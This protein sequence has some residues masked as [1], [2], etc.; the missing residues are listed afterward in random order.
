[1]RHDFAGPRGERLFLTA[2][3]FALA[4]GL[5]EAVYL[6]GVEKVLLGKRISSSLHAAWMIPVADL[7]FFLAPAAV[8]AVLGRFQPRLAA[9]GLVFGLFSALTAAS[10]LLATE[11]LH[12]AAVVLLAAGVGVEAARRLAP[13]A[14]RVQAFMRRTAPWLA[15]MVVLAA[16]TVTGWQTLRELRALAALPPARPGSPNVLLLVMDTVRA[17]SVSAHGYG[18]PTTPNLERLARQGIRFRWAMA[19]APWTLPTHASIFTGRLPH[20]LSGDWE[21]PLDGAHPTLAEALAALGYRTAGFS[22]NLTFVTWEWGLARGFSRF[23]DYDVSLAQAL[24]SPALGRSLT[25]NR[26]VRHVLGIRDR[27]NRRRAHAMNQSLLRWVDRDRSR[28]FF[29]FVNYFDAHEPYLPPGPF[30][31]RFGPLPARPWILQDDDVTMPPA[32]K[33]RMRNAYEA[34]IASLDHE[35]GNLMDALRRRGLLDNTVTVVTADHGEQFGEHGLLD[36]GNSLYLPLLHVP[37]IVTLPGG[38]AAGRV[39]EAT[40]SLR[41]LPATVMDLVGTGAGHPLPG[42]SLAS[43]WRGATDGPGAP[44]LASLTRGFERRPWIPLS[45][46]DMLSVVDDRYHYIRNGDGR[47]ELY[48]YRTDPAEERDLAGAPGHAEALARFRS[49]LGALLG[50]G[51]AAGR[52]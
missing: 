33:R 44:V 21:V 11:R 34:A 13:R 24:L 8:L 50:A 23:E 49:G 30:A 10:W 4:A 41:D 40:V 12:K 31:G 52:P 42:R 29:A 28:P 46:G 45:R 9:P 2:A 3:W 43:H 18:R 32:E 6:L 20:Q 51:V 19:P 17:A 35:I 5:G 48:E 26:L 38:E 39:V 47:E 16:L 37:L 1:M 22:A 36:H 25:E 15:A 27:L 7:V 14:A